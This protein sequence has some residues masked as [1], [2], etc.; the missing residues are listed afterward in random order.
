MSPICFAVF[1]LMTSSNLIGCSTG[2]STGLAPFMFLS[3]ITAARAFR[4][5]PI[6]SV[7]HQTATHNIVGSV[8][9]HWQ[10]MFERKVRRQI[11]D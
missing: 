6:R 11:W 9:Y 8:G 2:K 1:K 4:V 5:G 7:G 3:T 10:S